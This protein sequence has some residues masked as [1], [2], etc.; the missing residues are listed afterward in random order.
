MGGMIAQL[1]A[2]HYPFR[3]LSLTSIMSTSGHRSLPGAKAGVS[4]HMVKRPRNA[5]SAALQEYSAQTFRLIGSPKFPPSDEALR[6]KIARSYERSYY[7]AGYARH[8]AAILAGGDRVS[9]LKKIIAPTVNQ[10]RRP[11]RQRLRHA[12][13]VVTLTAVGFSSW[14]V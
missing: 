10:V 2:A 4:L 11:W 12:N 5:N 13:R 8:M 7:P 9:D 14:T 6:D 3:V 1:V